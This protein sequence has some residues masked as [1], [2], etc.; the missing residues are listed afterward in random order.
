MLLSP[1]VDQVY[2]NGAPG[3]YSLLHLA[4]ADDNASESAYREW[5][6][7]VGITLTGNLDQAISA[8]STTGDYT[9]MVVN[10]SDNTGK[11]IKDRMRFIFTTEKNSDPTG[12]TSAEGL[13]GM[14]LYPLN[15]DEIN[16]GIGDFF[17]AS[18]EPS[19]RL[20]VVTGNVRIREL[21]DAG[22]EMPT[23]E[24]F[25]V[26]DADGV[27]GWRDRRRLQVDTPYR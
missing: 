8:T 11:E 14:R 18:D 12:A 4:D 16:V 25:V 24:K 27:L 26:T 21:P 5:M 20:D 15:D 9:D 6:K 13:E 22:G 2:T 19:E 10:W 7:K 3:P 23:E 1:D 17:A